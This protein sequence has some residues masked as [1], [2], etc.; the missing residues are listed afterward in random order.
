LCTR[1]VCSTGYSYYT[2]DVAEIILLGFLLLTLI[3]EFVVLL[4]LSERKHKWSGV[5][6]YILTIGFLQELFYASSWLKQIYGFTWLLAVR[7]DI[8]TVPMLCFVLSFSILS[9]SILSIHESHSNIFLLI[10]GSYIFCSL[11]VIL[12]V[13]NFLDPISRYTDSAAKH[14]HTANSGII[15]SGND[16]GSYSYPYRNIVLEY[17]FIYLPVTG[18]LYYNRQHILAM[19]SKYNYTIII[20]AVV[21]V[22]VW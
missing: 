10:Y 7:Y 21:V 3:F 16:C 18:L 11:M 6:F 5:L 13:Q 22:I 15:C 12:L 9:I 17:L 8:H 4:K 2:M 19:I 14:N 1:Y 20:W